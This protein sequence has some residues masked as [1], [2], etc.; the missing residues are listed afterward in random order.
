M[1]LLLLLFLGCQP[2]NEI[3]GTL[4]GETVTIASAW[5]TQYVSVDGTEHPQYRVTLS[6][7][8]EGCQALLDYVADLDDLNTRYDDGEITPEEF[9][10]EAEE[11]FAARLPTELWQVVVEFLVPDGEFTELRLNGSDWDRYPQ[12]N[13]IAAAFVHQTGLRYSGAD[14]AVR[15]IS[16]QGNAEVSFNDK[17]QTLEGD[18]TTTASDYMTGLAFDEVMILWEVDICEGLAFEDAAVW[19]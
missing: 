13:E 7:M 3:D 11:N 12:T 5:W 8:E 9:V 14:L 16:D 19:W 4:E 1:G 2:T 10:A 15:Y 18:F 6:S 17:K